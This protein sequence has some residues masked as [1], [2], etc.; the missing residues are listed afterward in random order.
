MEASELRDRIL[1]CLK[2]EKDF[3][4]IV[5]ANIDGYFCSAADIAVPDSDGNIGVF[6]LAVVKHGSAK[7]I[8]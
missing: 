8:T 4:G 2:K 1:L 7:H 6:R 5:S 3:S